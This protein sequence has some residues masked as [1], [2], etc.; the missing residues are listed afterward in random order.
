MILNNTHV[1]GIFMYKSDIEYEK[2]DFVVSGNSIYICTAG[3]PTNTE[4]N[5]VMG[6]DPA[7]D[8]EN[9][10]IYLGDSLDN[11][12]EYFSYIEDPNPE[13]NDKVLTAQLLSEILNTYMIGFDEKGVIG[14][15]V[16]SDGGG[17]SLSSG[18]SKFLDGTEDS[19]V[20]DNILKIGSINNATFKV[21]RSLEQIKDIFPVLYKEGSI[22][23]ED[24]EYL[25]LR[26]YTYTNGT[27]PNSV[28]SSLYRVQELVDPV[29]GLTAY[30]YAKGVGNNESGDQFDWEITSWKTDY[31]PDFLQS[32][33][34]LEEAY[35]QAIEDL[36]KE[37]ENLRNYFRFKE[38]EILKTTGEV[39]L[40]CDDPGGDF[41][42]PVES[43]TTQSCVITV[44][45]QLWNTNTTISI[46]I[47]DSHMDISN[48]L[49]YYLTDSSSLTIEPFQKEEFGKKVKVRVNNG[50]IT[51][52]Y[53]RENY[54]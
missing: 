6:K 42:I 50:N 3:N 49:T 24:L 54:K 29:Q 36:K 37:K 4:N 41:Y 32:I 52:I 21:S 40:Q 44:I 30:R 25:I 7:E 14:E 38:F 31:D 15:Y 2:G 53:Y 46:D 20:L 28:D 34:K 33:N 5:T 47:L 35:R 18:L 12:E 1:Q 8:S 27:D 22:S 23:P 11:I 43:F 19:A 13:K 39:T 9:Y 16:Y 17:I 45:A 26:Q 51:N 10:T 48:I